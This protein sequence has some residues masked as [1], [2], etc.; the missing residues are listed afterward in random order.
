MSN[1]STQ[2]KALENLSRLYLASMLRGCKT[3][4]EHFKAD[5][6]NMPAFQKALEMAHKK[7]GDWDAKILNAQ[8]QLLATGYDVPDSWMAIGV[9]G[10]VTCGREIVKKKP[11][12]FVQV[13]GPDTNAL[14]KIC[15]EIR[16]AQI[17]LQSTP[18]SDGP[19]SKSDT[20]SRWG[21]IFGYSA[22]TF[23]RRVKNGK[24]RVIKNSDK[25]YQVHLN[26]LP[27]DQK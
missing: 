16:I 7:S 24:I 1:V 11:V 10:N 14:G 17:R 19:W 5:D 8:R 26:D 18:E 23:V 27:T 6:D 15:D 9:A 4:T 2:L 21:K 13:S 12:L 22:R 25:S 3:T 20:P